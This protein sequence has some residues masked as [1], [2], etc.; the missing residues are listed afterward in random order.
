MREP[1]IES[2]RKEGVDLAFTAISGL[3][4]SGGVIVCFVYLLLT[5]A[6]V[7][8]LQSAFAQSA[9]VAA[10]VRLEAGIEKEDVDG[11]LKSAMDIYQKIAADSAA[12]RH[13]RAQ[14]LLRLAG[15][16][17][18]L[19]HQATR[20]YE[21]IVHDYA[22][23]PA[24]AQARN[25]LALLK[26]Q[27]HPALPA[28]MS[29]RKIE[30]SGLGEMSATTTDGE[31]A[32]YRASDGNLY[33]GDVAGRNRRLVFRPQ[34]KRLFNWR[35]SPDF[36]MI[37]LT[38]KS[39]PGEPG[40]LAV[41]KSDGTGYREV[42]HDD[43]QGTLLTFA[44]ASLDWSWDN[45]YLVLNVYKP[46]GSRFFV[47]S[48]TDGQQRELKLPDSTCLSRAAFSPDGR[49]IAYETMPACELKTTGAHRTFVMPAEGGEPR[50]VYESKQQTAPGNDVNLFKDWTADGRY[51]MI[52][53][54]SRD[55]R[56]ALF[57]LPMTDGAAAGAAQM[58]RYGN[59]RW[60]WTAASGAF[61]Y[62]DNSTRPAESDVFAASLDPGGHLA[63]WHRL[64]L[65]GGRFPNGDHS[66]SFSSDSAELFY[67]APGTERGKTDL[68]LRELSTGQERV[69][70]QL[71][72]AHINCMHASSSPTIQC[73]SSE[74]DGKTKLVSVTAQS[75]ETEQISSFDRPRIILQHSP[76]DKT[77]YLD[78]RTYDG[79]GSIF[80]WDL[81]ARIETKLLSEQERSDDQI[82]PSPDGKWLVRI[83]PSELSVM[84]L[85]GGKWKSLVSETNGIG[86][87]N[88]VSPDSNW[89]IYHEHDP[90]GADWLA[91]V[92]IAG[93]KPE[94]LGDFPKNCSDGY[95]NVSPDGRQVLTTCYR[96]PSA[97]FDDEVWA[98]EN[99]V[100]SATK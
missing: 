76:D 1:A 65:R 51:L 44:P 31:R 68:V 80:Q 88:A 34:Q 60:S 69:L 89:V 18:K 79:P 7:M 38:F 43:A 26:Q 15:C 41:V 83:R 37:S 25:R 54:L 85:S 97:Y 35:P 50:L 6:S 95:L 100:P 55:G 81:A 75:G 48:V 58:V 84:P 87:Q 46:G 28:T 90:A 53:D 59:F 99:Y 16:D 64:D 2:T 93:G 17:E 12:P 20:V 61:V 63:K 13:V 56:S 82:L 24:A 11:D 9:P 4:L 72:G 86:W 71:S 73:A 42:F 29:V 91:R 10:G 21:Q 62:Q 49:F 39:R 77:I 19:G 22:D 30:A 57:L 78:S 96:N 66:P 14:A 5:V 47:L 8:T 36:S 94:R 74:N 92:S 67:L 3:L 32:I 45:R 52:Q 27:E 33:F 70:Y 23:M 98:L 40:F